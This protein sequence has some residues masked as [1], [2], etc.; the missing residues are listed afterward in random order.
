MKQTPPSERAGQA[1]LRLAWVAALLL[2]MRLGMGDPS[3][4]SILA[5][6]TATLIGAFAFHGDAE[7]RATRRSK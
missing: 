3:A 4:A 1:M 5:I 2:V 6:F 7:M